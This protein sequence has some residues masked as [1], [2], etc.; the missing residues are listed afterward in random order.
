MDY[1]FN[2]QPWLYIVVSV[3]KPLLSDHPAVSAALYYRESL[4]YTQKERVFQGLFYNNYSEKNAL[5]V[6]MCLLEEVFQLFPFVYSDFP[7]KIGYSN[8]GDIILPYNHSFFPVGSIFEVEKFLISKRGEVFFVLN[9]S[10][11]GRVITSHTRLIMFPEILERF[12]LKA[13]WN[14]SGLGFISR[15]ILGQKFRVLINEQYDGAQ[16]LDSL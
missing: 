15:R 3:R 8:H 7:E 13:S 5:L 12:Q 1:H 6:E 11:E 16:K 4:L 9:N 2:I 14:D 10:I